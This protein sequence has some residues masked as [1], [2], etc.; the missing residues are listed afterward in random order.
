MKLGFRNLTF[1]DA[2]SNSTNK[3]NAFRNQFVKMSRKEKR[4]KGESNGGI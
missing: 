3:L 1:H 2:V 4:Y